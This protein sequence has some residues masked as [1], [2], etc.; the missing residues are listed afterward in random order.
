MISTSFEFTGNESNESKRQNKSWRTN[1]RSAFQFHFI[2]LSIAPVGAHQT[3]CQKTMKA[4]SIALVCM[5][6]AAS[7]VNASMFSLKC[8]KLPLWYNGEGEEGIQL[9]SVPKVRMS[10]PGEWHMIELFDDP[11]EQYDPRM[12]KTSALSRAQDL[13]MIYAYGITITGVYGRKADPDKP[14]KVV[15]DISKAEQTHSFSIMEVARAAANCIRDLFPQNLGVP[16]VLK[17]KAK[18]AVFEPPFD[19]A[20][21]KNEKP[22]EQVV[23]PNGT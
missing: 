4:F 23:S 5:L 7:A 11:F 14:L 16:L 13:N 21:K 15:I 6:T 19:N 22:A 17:D 12:P 20:N 9:I 10:T 8:I 2:F 3:F 18:E 1:R